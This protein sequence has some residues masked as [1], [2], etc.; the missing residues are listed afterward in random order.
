ML[1]QSC[2]TLCDPMDCGLPDSSVHSISQAR[3][4][5]SGLPF[6]SPGHLPN[7]GIELWSPALQAYSLPSEPPG[8]P[9]HKTLNTLGTQEMKATV[10]T[11]GYSSQSSSLVKRGSHLSKPV[12]SSDGDLCRKLPYVIHFLEIISSRLAKLQQ[13]CASTEGSCSWLFPW[14]TFGLLTHWRAGLL[15]Q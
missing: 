6:L 11:N 4:L 9:L 15:T 1:A 5:E 3:I 8:K 12:C 7:L 13:N 2:L 14:K 10:I